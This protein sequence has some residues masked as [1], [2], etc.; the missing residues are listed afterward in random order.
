MDIKLKK[1]IFRLLSNLDDFVG[2]LYKFYHVSYNRN[3]HLVGSIINY[4][5]VILD[6]IEEIMTYPSPLPN[7]YYELINVSKYLVQNLFI[8]RCINMDLYTLHIN[9]FEEVLD[10]FNDSFDVSD[11]FYD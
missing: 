5:S 11:L 6:T 2:D 4:Q 3:H 1:L 9:S 10:L 8:D 7:D